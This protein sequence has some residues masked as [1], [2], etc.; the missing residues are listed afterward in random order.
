MTAILRHLELDGYGVVDEAATDIIALEQA[1][2]VAEPWSCALFIDAIVNLQ[3][4]RQLRAARPIDDVQFFDRSPICI[5]ALGK[6]FS[7]LS[8]R[9]FPAKSS[10]S[11]ANEFTS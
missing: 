4:D 10:E 9:H 3:R 8:S 11:S 1:Q 7:Y 5:Y 6:Y 2:G